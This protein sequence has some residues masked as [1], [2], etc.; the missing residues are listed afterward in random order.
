M[1]PVPHKR[2]IRV[3]GYEGN[4]EWVR[5]VLAQS[6]L[7]SPLKTLFRKQGTVREIIR[8][9]L[10]EGEELAGLEFLEKRPKRP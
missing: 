9:D 4:E 2:V 8:I 10:A 7:R 6:P 5:R 1:D 3:I